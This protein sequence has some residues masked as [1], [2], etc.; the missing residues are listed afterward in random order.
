M[1]T[2]TACIHSGVAVACHTALYSNNTNAK[3][4]RSTRALKCK[5]NLQYTTLVHASPSGQ[6]L[7]TYRTTLTGLQYNRTATAGPSLALP[8]FLRAEP[9]SRLLVHHNSNTWQ[10][11][12]TKPPSHW[13]SRSR[14]CSGTIQAKQHQKTCAALMHRVRQS[15]HH[16]QHCQTVLAQK[17]RQ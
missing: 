8:F 15:T 3:L 10:P 2:C 6:A 16:A 4:G 12:N 14:I 1:Q 13:C 7:T 17:S 11:T 9:T 5:Y